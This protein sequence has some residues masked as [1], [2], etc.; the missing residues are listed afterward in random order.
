MGREVLTVHGGLASTGLVT[1]R[2]VVVLGNGWELAGVAHLPL[3]N[4]DDRC[5]RVY[6]I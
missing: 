2:T 6:Y 5:I 3:Q 4:L 1:M